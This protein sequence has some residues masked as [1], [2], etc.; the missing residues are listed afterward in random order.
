MIA[1]THPIVVVYYQCQDSEE[2]CT[3]TSALTPDGG[4]INGVGALTQGKHLNVY[5]VSLIK[6]HRQLSCTVFIGWSSNLEN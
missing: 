4:L 1:D 3:L 2:Y 6:L 5:P